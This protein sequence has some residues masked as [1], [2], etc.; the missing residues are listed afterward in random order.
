MSTKTPSPTNSNESETCN[1][2]STLAS[3]TNEHTYPLNGNVTVSRSSGTTSLDSENVSLYSTSK[4]V[5]KMKKFLTTLYHFARDIS[6]E[7]G[8]NVHTLINGL[9]VNN[10]FY[11]YLSYCHTIWWYDWTSR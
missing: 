5:A 10:F 9:V 7:V 3:F 11:Y 6:G 4:Q 2:A 8:D 1:K